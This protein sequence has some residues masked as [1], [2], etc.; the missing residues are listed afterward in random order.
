MKGNKMHEIRVTHK[1]NKTVVASLLAETQVGCM[2]MLHAW[3]QDT[4]VEQLEEY[5]AIFLFDGGL[6]SVIWLCDWNDIVG[7]VETSCRGG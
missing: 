5:D 1:I 6:T 3:F 2:T 4:D 7:M